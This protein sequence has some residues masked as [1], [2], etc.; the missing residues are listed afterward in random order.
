MVQFIQQLFLQRIEFVNE[1]KVL[2]SSVLHCI[3][4]SHL[5]LSLEKIKFGFDCFE[6]KLIDLPTFPFWLGG[7]HRRFFT[8]AIKLCN[9]FIEISEMYEQ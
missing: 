4:P 1:M 9:D 2:I 6:V 3:N 5:N 7:L 8:G